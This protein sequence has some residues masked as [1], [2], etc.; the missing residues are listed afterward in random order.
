MK[1]R[2]QVRGRISKE[3]EEDYS[4]FAEERR[5]AERAAWVDGSRTEEDQTH[6]RPLFLA[7]KKHFQDQNGFPNW[8]SPKLLGHK[9]LAA[10]GLMP[11]QPT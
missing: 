3:A 10:R 2:P 11:N 7:Q 8:D 9:G 6:L 4:R 5:P 1:K